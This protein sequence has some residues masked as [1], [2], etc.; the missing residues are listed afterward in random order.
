MADS[1]RTAGDTAPLS[2]GE[3]VGGFCL[4]ILCQLLGEAMVQLLRAVVPG[5]IFPGPVAGLILLLL[6]L[7]QLRRGRKSVIG[8]AQSLLGVLTLLFV[9]AAVGIIEHGELLKQWGLPLLVAVIVSTL[10]TL[11]VTVGAFI[12]TQAVLDRRQP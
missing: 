11:L 4:L 10:L 12:A 7:P 3:W 2:P 8:A 9:P 6:L 1:G 5:L